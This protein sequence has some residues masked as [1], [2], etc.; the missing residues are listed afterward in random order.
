MCTSA[1]ID[2]QLCDQV[3]IQNSDQTFL[4]EYKIIIYYTNDD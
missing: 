1:N 3:S 2:G 4:G